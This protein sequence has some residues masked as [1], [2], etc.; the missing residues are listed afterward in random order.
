LPASQDGDD[1]LADFVGFFTP[2]VDLFTNWPWMLAGAGVDTMTIVRQS[3]YF[4]GKAQFGDGKP[5]ILVPEF[6]NKSAFPTALELAQGAWLS[7]G[8]Y[9]PVR[10]CR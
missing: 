9:G 2:A 4:G 1:T 6:S 3:I 8:D 7:P 5:I 10:E